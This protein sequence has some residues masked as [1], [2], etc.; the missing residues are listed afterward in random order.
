MCLEH[1][2]NLI[3]SHC[4]IDVTDTLVLGSAQ[5]GN[6]V[7]FDKAPSLSEHNSLEPSTDLD[8]FSPRF[9]LLAT[10]P[11]SGKSMPGRYAAYVNVY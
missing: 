1:K 5:W 10:K 2:R 9:F 6:M 11:H 7:C 3:A 4:Y 8:F